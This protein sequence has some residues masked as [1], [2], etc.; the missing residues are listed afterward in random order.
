MQAEQHPTISTQ[1]AAKAPVAQNADS[2]TAETSSRGV[3]LLALATYFA[4]TLGE[5]QHDK[6]S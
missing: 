6:I 1:I 4:H 2:R 5:Y 3:P